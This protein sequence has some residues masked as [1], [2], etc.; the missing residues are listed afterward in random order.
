[1]QNHRNLRVWKHAHLLAIAVRRATRS[2]PRGEYGALHTQITKAAE[3][4]LF[5]IIE[6]CGASTPREFARFLDMGIKSSKELEGQ[7]E[8]AKDY[9]VLSVS[10]ARELTRAI[11][12]VRKMLCGLRAKVLES[13]NPPRPKRRQTDNGQRQTPN[14][15]PPS[16][17]PDANP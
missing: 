2:F 10:V 14:V 12:D 11:I 1:M 17:A 4:V 16:L 13:V 9:G 7:I 15:D 8:L 5:T 3:S 6:G